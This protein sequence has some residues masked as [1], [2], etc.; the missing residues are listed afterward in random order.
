MKRFLVFIL[1]LCSVLT[2]TAQQADSSRLSALSLKLDEYYETLKHESLDVQKAECDFLIGSATDSLLRQHIALDIYEHYLNSPIMG[3][4]NVAVHVFDKWIDSGKVKMRSSSDFITAQVHADFNRQSLLGSKAPELRMLLSDGSGEELFTENDP[5]GVFRVLYFYDT[6]CAKCRIETLFLK[7][8]IDTGKYPVEFYA[9]YVGDDRD[10]WEKYIS[11]ALGQDTAI[12]MWDPSLD[13]D[14]QRKYGVLKTPRLFLVAPDETIIGRGLDVKSLEV[15]LEGIFADNSLDYGTP[16]SEDLFDGIFAAS[17]GRPS[18][19]EVKGIADYIHDRTIARGDT[20]MFR[21]MSG[22]YL[23]YL[24]SHSGEGYKE[25]LKYHIE[26]NILSAD[27]V[28]K[29]EDDSLKIIGFAQILNDLLSRALPGSLVP[30]IKVPGELYS[31]RGVKNVTMRL[32]K[33][34]G[35]NNIILFYTEGCEICAAEKEAAKALLKDRKTKV[36]MVNI[37]TLMTENPSL[38]SRLMDAFDLSSLPHIIRTDSK[39]TV[40]GRYISLAGF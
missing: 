10:S 19:G 31:S 9:I 16:E 29:T 30:D 40:L 25:G 23:Y 8:L 27:K 6:D 37:D 33:L 26:K 15:L 38:A 5:S 32:P 39:G 2:L 34:R 4:E 22:D 36:F 13:S 11:E 18:A 1:L 12:H 17:A 35:R 14:F 21:Q 7:K 28:W 3:A 20:L 24:A